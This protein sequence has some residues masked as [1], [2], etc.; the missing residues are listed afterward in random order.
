MVHK[1]PISIQKNK[2]KVVLIKV[3]Q[4]ANDFHKSGY[5]IIIIIIKI[6]KHPRVTLF[7]TLP[8]KI[9]KKKKKKILD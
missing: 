4:Y 6:F 7:Y 9:T 2:P 8:S 3:R 1:Y 5:I